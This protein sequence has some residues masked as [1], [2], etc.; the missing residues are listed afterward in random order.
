MR[1]YV[2]LVIFLV[3]LLSSCKTTNPPRNW[4]RNTK[5]PGQHISWGVKPPK[6]RTV[7][8]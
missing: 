8:R 7:Y 5:N 1:S 2:F 3:G 4:S 6:N